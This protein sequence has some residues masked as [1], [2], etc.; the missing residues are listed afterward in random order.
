MVFLQDNSLFDT[1]SFNNRQTHTHTHMHTCANT[2]RSQENVYFRIEYD[3]PIE[4]LLTIT[5]RAHIS[6]NFDA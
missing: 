4:K 6:G 2:T 1:F 3:V 5:L